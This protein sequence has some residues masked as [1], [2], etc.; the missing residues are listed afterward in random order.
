LTLPI[1]VRITAAYLLTVAVLTAFGAAVFTDA[2]HLGVD[3]R[4]DGQLRS[5]AVRLAR[6]VQRDGPSAVHAATPA[7]SILLTELIH[8]AVRTATFSPDLPG[9]GL[10]D[11]DQQAS[12]RRAGGFRTVGPGPDFRLYGEPAPAADGVWLVVIA[13]PLRE[14]NALSDTVSGL[15]IASGLV[16]LVLGGLSAWL[17]AGAALRPVERLR[18]EVAEMSESDPSSPVRVPATGDEVAR[19]AET[20]NNLLARISMALAQQRQFVADASH[21]VRAPLANLRI[22]LELARTRARTTDELADAVRACEHEVIRLGRLVDDLLVLAAADERVPVERLPEQPL[23]PLLEAAAVAAA[24]AAEAKDITLRVASDPDLAAALHPGLIRQVLDN[25]LGNA[26]R[27]APD[28][29]QVSVSATARDGSLL[30]EVTD[31]GPGFPD[32]FAEHAFERFRQAGSGRRRGD[33]GSGLGLAVVLAIARAHGGEA[34]AGNTPAGGGVVRVSVP[35]IRDAGG[36][37]S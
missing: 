15:L 11:P 19:L 29:S 22:T 5:R 2:V 36:Q 20:M 24:S 34:E 1:R 6:E 14:E 10:L 30:L 27:H 7:N 35:L 17:L 12:L 16:V 33:G 26:V 28:G 25:L 18:R 21:E 37:S 23:S 9:A 8:P 3:R 4:L 32:G 13:T 31:E